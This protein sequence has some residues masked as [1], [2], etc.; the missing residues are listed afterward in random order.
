MYCFFNNFCDCVQPAGEISCTSCRKIVFLPAVPFN[1]ESL[2]LNFCF[3]VCFRLIK[4]DKLILHFPL[5]LLG[6][7]AI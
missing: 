6:L 5:E 1:T 2:N 7:V 4:F 3:F